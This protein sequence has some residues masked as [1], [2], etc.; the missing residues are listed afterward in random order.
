MKDRVPNILTASRIVLL[1]P[2]VTLFFM[3]GRSLKWI[4][5]G[6]YVICAVTD[7]FD[8]YLARSWDK[9]SSLGRFL[10]PIA[11]KILVSVTI[12]LLVSTHK[13]C[14]LNVIAALIILAREIFIS[15]LREFLS[16]HNVRMP[17]TYFA[18]VKTTAQLIALGFL[19]V[20]VDCSP[21]DIELVTVNQWSHLIGTTL[22]WIAAVVSVLTG[23][24]YWVAAKPHFKL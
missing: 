22:L 21:F 11:D 7:F 1:L 6:I 4:A 17:S 15:G 9:T 12:V 14:G 13:I 2:F 18:Q 10:D 24:Q 5:L 8:G 16:E 20:S 19:I 3:Q 23:L